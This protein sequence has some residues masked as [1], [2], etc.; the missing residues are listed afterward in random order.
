MRQPDVLDR[1]MSKLQ[2]LH[3]IP[4]KEAAELHAAL[5]EEFGGE[6]ST[7]YKRSAAEKAKMV[8]TALRKLNGHNA[9]EIARE[10]GVSRATV[11]R[12]IKQPGGG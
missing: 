4:E 5:R 11:Y 1:L 2:D 8:N 10:L 3:P 12:Y 6:R 9:T 7:I